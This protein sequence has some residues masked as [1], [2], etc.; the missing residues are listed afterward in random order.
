MQ[1][2]TTIIQLRLDENI[3]YKTLPIYKKMSIDKTITK[4][5]DRVFIALQN[6]VGKNK[7]LLILHDNEFNNILYNYVMEDLL[8]NKNISKI[9]TSKVLDIDRVIHR[10]TTNEFDLDFI[11]RQFKMYTSE[12]ISITNK[13][14]TYDKKNKTFNVHEKNLTHPVSKI[15][16]III[17]NK[18]TLNYHVFE[19]AS[20]QSYIIDDNEL[21]I[22]RRY[23]TITNSNLKLNVFLAKPFDTTKKREYS[24]D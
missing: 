3:K 19:L 21:C 16:K 24:L 18:S 2:N 6:M 10:T 14:L 13:R 20:N 23:E 12:F 22:G 1:T 5:I 11:K 4:I 17:Y 7:A 8:S 15:S 9:F